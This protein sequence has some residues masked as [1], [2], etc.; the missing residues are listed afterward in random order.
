MTYRDKAADLI[1]SYVLDGEGIPE[2]P[3]QFREPPYAQS[4]YRKEFIR[5]MERKQS[6]TLLQWASKRQV[7][8]EKPEV[9]PEGKS[10]SQKDQDFY[11]EAWKANQDQ[12]GYCRCE[13]CGERLQYAASHVSHNLS[14]G[15]NPNPF[16]R[17]N[18]DNVSILC[19]MHHTQWED[20]H[21]R[22]RMK[23]WPVKREEMKGLLQAF[24]G[25]SATHQPKPLS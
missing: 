14:R 24:V 19:V 16:F 18:V 17:W 20:S 7:R 2:R 15:A 4:A 8:Y 11:H 12:W 3:K 22:K 21:K 1:A 25:E 6:G 5:A 23:I 10:L 13:E 9:K